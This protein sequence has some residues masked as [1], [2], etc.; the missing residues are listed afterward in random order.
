MPR[1]EYE[2]DHNERKSEQLTSSKNIETN[3]Q[4]APEYVL[5]RLVLVDLAED[6]ALHRFLP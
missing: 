5:E 2:L 3:S 4:E 1:S 6:N